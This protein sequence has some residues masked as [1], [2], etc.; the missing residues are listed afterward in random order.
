MCARKVMR[1]CKSPEKKMLEHLKVAAPAQ[2][3]N[4]SLLVRMLID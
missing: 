2:V 4:T 1:E 3:N